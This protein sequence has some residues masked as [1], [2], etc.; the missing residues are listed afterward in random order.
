MFI[1]VLLV[2]MRYNNVLLNYYRLY[3][4]TSSSNIVELVLHERWCGGHICIPTL[5][6][7]FVC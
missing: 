6:Q 5:S 4:C 7:E 1:I 2:G 3:R